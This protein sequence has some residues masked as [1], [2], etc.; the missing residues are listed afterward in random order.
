MVTKPS[1]PPRAP[2]ASTPA[3]AHGECCS[4]TRGEWGG[5]IDESVHGDSGCELAERF[6]TRLGRLPRMLLRI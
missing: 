5:A 4:G 3:T 6:W 1:Q 2:Q